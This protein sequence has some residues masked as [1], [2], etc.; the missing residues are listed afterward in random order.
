MQMDKHSALIIVDVQNDFLPG[1]A[2]GVTD[3][4]KIIPYINKIQQQ[5]GVTI[6]TKDWHPRNHCSFYDQ[7]PGKVVGD[8]IIL[9]NPT[10]HQHCWP[11]HCVQDTMGAE[12][13]A[14][15][16]KSRIDLI[17]HKGDDPNKNAYS[18]FLDDCG[19]KTNL[20]NYLID[21]EI[22]SVYI[23]GLATD[24][25]VKETA[26]DAVRFNFNTH[27]IL[28]GCRAV[29]L[30]PRDEMMSVCDMLDE[31]VSVRRYL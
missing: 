27:V 20:S 24:F 9:E 26:I 3:G 15:L 7:H 8:E 10:R 21:R 6:A 12:L 5:F 28:E 14:E 19:G 17:L 25:C 2:L 31:G 29:N 1:G 4:N 22:Y 18:A 30:T 13:S 11:V 16:D 23:V